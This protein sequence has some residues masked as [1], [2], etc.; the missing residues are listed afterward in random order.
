VPMHEVGMDAKGS[1]LMTSW[2][3]KPLA[4]FPDQP[5]DEVK[6]YFG[7]RIGLYFAF[8]QHLVRC[9]VLPSCVGA[10]VLLGGLY[11]DHA[12]GEEV[13]D[14]HLS[15]AYSMFTLVWISCVA[16]LWR[17]TE[18]R[19]AFEWSAQ[20]HEASEGERP[21]FRGVSDAR[22]IY[23]RVGYFV[24]LEEETELFEHAPLNKRFTKMERLRRTALSYLI[25][26]PVASITMAAVSSILAYRTSLQF[27]F[28]AID[29]IHLEAW[30]VRIDFSSDEHV[31]LDFEE[32]HRRLAASAGVAN[33]PPLSD[34]VG[35]TSAVP[36]LA[37]IKAPSE[38]MIT[39]AGIL[40]GVLMALTI[41][42]TNRLYRAVA[43]WLNDWEN[44]RTATEYEDALILKTF[45][46]Q[47]VNSYF[48]LCYVSFVQSL[49][50]NIFPA[51][52]PWS[53]DDV[54]C[55]DMDHFLTKDAQ[56]IRDEHAGSNPYCMAELSS[57]LIG[58]SVVSQFVGKLVE[59]VVPRLQSVCRKN[60]IREQ[61][62]ADNKAKELAA[63]LQMAKQTGGIA[64]SGAEEAAVPAKL[65]FYERQIL[66]APYDVQDDI[67]KE[68]NRTLIQ[69]GY[70]VLFA[71]AFPL[72]S[73]VS[74]FSF[75]FEI[76][77]DAYKLLAVSQRPRY[78][79]CQDIGSWMTVIEALAVMCV[80][81]NVGIIG[82][83]S[84]TFTRS[85]PLYLF[86]LEV[87]DKESKLLGLVI[88]VGLILSVR[89]VINCFLPDYPI[90]IAEKQA[91]RAWRRKVTATKQRLPAGEQF[92]VFGSGAIGKPR[93]QWDDGELD[94]K[95][96]RQLDV[97][98]PPAAAETMNA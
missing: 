36:S 83:T 6:E 44:H 86:G 94:A 2:C 70:V 78:R 4:I 80:L 23:S 71:P 7:E 52:L 13:M 37:V 1:R 19:L 34:S 53:L 65:S 26:V 22:G 76:R 8:M 92:V 45:T 48:A 56:K 20:E 89:A 21:E 5:L 17:N 77:T 42:I 11:L 82:Y 74:Y 62:K 15:A 79:G 32:A 28:A 30:N 90:E 49:E 25:V 96:R 3:L 18:A 60:A 24:D 61:A 81:T 41:Q 72:A 14:N 57:M 97:M 33:P 39:A 73:L 43:V 16:K 88:L 10:A 85:L 27:A 9:L 55:H 51:W 47:A 31:E 87:V 66:R 95:F 68:Y 98:L 54:F 64:A 75:L 12:Y 59:V 63:A 40:G 38:W 69:L 46:F 67:F 35:A 93:E 29:V 91:R 58:M 84:T 50:L